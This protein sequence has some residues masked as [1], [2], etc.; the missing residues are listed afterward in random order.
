[1]IGTRI[2]HDGVQPT[3]RHSSQITVDSGRRPARRPRTRGWLH[4]AATESRW[5]S[6]APA[7]RPISEKATARRRAASF[8]RCVCGGV[9]TGCRIHVP[10]CRCRRIGPRRRVDRGPGRPTVQ[11]CSQA[12]PARARRSALAHGSSLRPDHRARPQHPA[13]RGRAGQRGLH[14]CRP[15]RLSARPQ[16]VWRWNASDCR[17]CCRGSA[18]RRES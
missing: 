6:A 12:A 14:P 3:T 13:P 4:W 9:P 8:T 17:G 2:E 11:S 18:P 1:M 15:A 5:H 7:S 10:C 16:V